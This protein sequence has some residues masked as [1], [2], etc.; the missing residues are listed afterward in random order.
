MNWFVDN[1]QWIITTCTMGGAIYGGIKGDL[2]LMH[3]KIDS[4]SE[5]LQ[6]RLDSIRADLD[7]QTMQ[8]DNLRDH[9]GK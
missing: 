5:H 9:S 3:Q 7:Y 4:T 8:I 2:K 1:I 6:Q